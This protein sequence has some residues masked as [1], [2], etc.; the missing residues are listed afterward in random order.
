MK[1]EIKFS[2]SETSEYYFCRNSQ[3]NSG[4][5]TY[6]AAAENKKV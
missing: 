1:I 6:T 5:L 3:L 2:P 4:V